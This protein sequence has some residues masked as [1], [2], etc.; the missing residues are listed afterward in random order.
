MSVTIR[1]VAREALVSVA[2]VSRVLNGKGPVHA[3]T[4]RRIRKAA[5]RL[6]YVPHGGARSLITRK[7]HTIGVLLPDLYGEFFSE[8]IRGIDLCARRSGYHVVVSSSHSNRAETESMFRAMRGRVDGLIVLYPGT[9]PPVRKGNLP[10]G[11]PVVLLNAPGSRS[12]DSLNIDNFGGAFAMVRHL[13]SLGHRRIAFIGGPAQNRDAVERLRGYREAVRASSA[14]ESRSLEVAGDFREWAGYDAC[15]SIR[16]IRPRPS[17]I[18]A[19]NDAMAIGLLC[20][21]R[22]KGIRVPEQYAIAGF[23][24][25]PIARYITPPLTSVRVPI[26]ALGEQATLRVLKAIE[27]GPRHEWREET[28]PTAL[29]IRES[30]GAGARSEDPPAPRG[31]GLSSVSESHVGKNRQRLSG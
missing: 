20:A 31:R 25:I 27:E 15:R 9:R 22:E 26:S 6:H 13:V 3:D 7:T 11:F 23:D 28:L 14:D 17:A 18:F 16:S 10:D 24:D 30:C 8:V 5:K 4:E 2:T 21:F 19:A 1:E 29:V 12:F